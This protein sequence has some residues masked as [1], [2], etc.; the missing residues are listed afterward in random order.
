MSQKIVDGEKPQAILEFLERF[1]RKGELPAAF[2]S[3]ENEFL[4]SIQYLFDD[5]W[6][7]HF[8]QANNLLRFGVNT[9]GWDL[10]VDISDDE[11]VILQDEMGDIDTI[12]I[13]IFDLLGAKVERV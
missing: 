9:D 10:L 3:Q 7:K 6:S 4:V 2:R 13:T 8:D 5:C 11:L 12:D 1:G